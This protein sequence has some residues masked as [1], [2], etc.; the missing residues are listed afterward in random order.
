MRIDFRQT[1]EQIP[2]PEKQVTAALQTGLAAGRQQQH[3]RHR[4][5]IIGAVAAAAVLVTVTP[6]AVQAGGVIPMIQNMLDQGDKP[7]HNFDPTQDALLGKLAKNGDYQKV[8]IPA[9]TKNGVSVKINGLFTTTGLVGILYDVHGEKVQAE[10]LKNGMRPAASTQQQNATEPV[11]DVQISTE[12][13]AAGHYRVLAAFYPT[14]L[15]LTQ[16]VHFDLTLHH[17]DGGS[18]A[19]TF[20]G[21][22]APAAP[23]RTVAVNQSQTQAPFTGTLA[24]IAVGRDTMV[25]NYNVT[26]A[27]TALTARQLTGIQQ[28]A[29]ISDAPILDSAGHTLGRL[30]L[31]TGGQPLTVQ[32]QSSHWQANF[33][34][35]FQTTYSPGDGS[36]SKDLT[37]L[38]KGSAIQFTLELPGHGVQRTILAKFSVP[39]ASLRSR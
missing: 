5:V 31:G 7:T 29:W 4:R 2:V 17:L 15:D 23:T 8:T 38:P 27:P 3:R 30:D 20:T 32:K 6:I 26:F 10:N 34:S 25:V 21:L 18:T 35:I 37:T 39:V 9:Q 19:M 24:T 14:V 33:R 22:T 28:A 16:P 13:L 1:A 11:Y 12:K 36:V